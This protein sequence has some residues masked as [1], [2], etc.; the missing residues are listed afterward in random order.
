M[1]NSPDELFAD[2]PATVFIEGVGEV[3]VVYESAP[4]PEVLPPVDPAVVYRSA[5]GVESVHVGQ[6]IVL[7]N[8]VSLVSQ[9]LDPMAGL[10]WQCVDGTSSLTE[11]MADVGDAFGRSVDEVQTDFEPAVAVWIRDGFVVD[12]R[13]AINTGVEISGASTD[14]LDES[15][16]WRFL[17]DPPND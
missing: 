7:W 1:S 16:G 15:K 14:G 3:P 12:T 4:A 2:R 8:P 9:V 5:S 11:I 6:E 17:V 10:L 13:A